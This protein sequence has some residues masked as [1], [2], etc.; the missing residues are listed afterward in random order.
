MASVD[1][2]VV[3]AGVVGLAV[4]R[5]EAMACRD[6][7]IVEAAE[8]FG[9]GTSSRNSEVL[10]AGVFHP[11][12]WLKSRLCVAGRRAL[13]RYCV[14]RG[15]PHRRCGKLLVAT[16]EE[17]QQLLA[18]YAA[19]A[20]ANGLAGDE[21]LVPLS[22]DEARALEPE[23]RCVA[24]LESP[25]TAIVDS[26]A[27]MR[28]LLADAEARGAA[29]AYRSPMT[30]AVATANGFRVAT[31]GTDATE[32]GCRRLVNAAGLAAPELA[33]RIDAYD[34][35][36]IPRQYLTKGSY[37]TYR[38][39][40]PFQR[41]IYPPQ[42]GGFSVH[43]TIDL[44]GRLKFGPDAEPV[45]TLHYEV[46]PDRAARF[47]AAI[48]MWWPNLPDGGLQPGYAGV[49]PRLSAPGES[50]RDFVIEGPADHGVPGLVQLFGI[51]SPGLTS[52]L[53]I[54]DHVAML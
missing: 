9:T 12:G 10:H 43:A 13:V 15:I 26:H 48:R 18:T 20:Q 27:L 22:A 39:R 5:A 23:L 41:P 34:P 36:R 46:D 45:D 17:E 33:R 29:I 19:R 50:A 21:A 54:A 8:R 40:S 30:S 31:G 28:S 4:A 7:L 24:A 11:P 16:D 37:F 53:A 3:G 49:R 47:Y 6:V 38:G 35:A 25:A 52:C 1:T 32:V 51:E 44:A 14:E 42:R 2:I